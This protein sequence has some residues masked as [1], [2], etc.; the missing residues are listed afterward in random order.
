MRSR[1]V[2][3]RRFLRGLGGAAIALPLLQSLDTRPVGAASPPKRLV[4]FFTPNGTVKDQ[5]RPIGAG[6]GESDF[7]LS[8]ILEPLEPHRD[9]VLI[10]DGIDMESSYHGPGDNAHWSGMGH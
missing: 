8:P 4:I 1:A 7:T 2:N 6:A 3:R 5:W 10:L 9:D